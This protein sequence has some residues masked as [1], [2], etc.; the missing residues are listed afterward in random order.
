MYFGEGHRLKVIQSFYADTKHDSDLI[1]PIGTRG[2][3]IDGQNLYGYT[4]VEF[5]L[6]RK[7]HRERT[8]VTDYTGYVEDIDYDYPRL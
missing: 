6:G 8:V 5:W 3:V 2:K 1:I 7:R 4:T